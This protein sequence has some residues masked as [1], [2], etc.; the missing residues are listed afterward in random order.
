MLGVPTGKRGSN[1]NHDESA[2]T[3]SLNLRHSAQIGHISA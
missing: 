2:Q 1:T 3:D